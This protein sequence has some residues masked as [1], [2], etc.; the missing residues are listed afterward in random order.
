MS[1]DEQTVQNVREKLAPIQSLIEKEL[2]LEESLLNEEM[3]NI[4]DEKGEHEDPN[5]EDILLNEKN[6]SPLELVDSD[7]QDD[8]LKL[9][10]DDDLEEEAALL[11]DPVKTSELECPKTDSKFQEVI[12]TIEVEEKLLETLE[13][14]E[15]KTNQTSVTDSPFGPK[16]A[17]GLNKPDMMLEIP[18]QEFIE[19]SD[20]EGD[21]INNLEMSPDEELE[22]ENSMKDIDE[23]ILL[24]SDEEKSNEFLLLKD[25]AA[26]NNE[27]LNESSP[28]TDILPLEPKMDTEPDAETEVRLAADI[29]T[30]ELNTMGGENMTDQQENMLLQDD[31]D[32]TNELI[33]TL[34]PDN[35]IL[36]SEDISIVEKELH[37]N[38]KSGT[39][40]D[41]ILHS[42]PNESDQSTAGKTELTSVVEEIT[43]E[44][45]TE[46]DMLT[47]NIENEPKSIIKEGKIGTKDTNVNIHEE[48]VLKNSDIYENQDQDTLNEK[49]LK[50]NQKT[51]SKTG[52]ESLNVLEIDQQPSTSYALDTKIGKTSDTKLK[53]SHLEK[54]ASELPKV[55]NVDS[56]NSM[57]E[58]DVNEMSDS[59]GLLAETS[60][61]REED[62]EPEDDEDGDGDEDDD[63]DNYEDG[64]SY[65]W[66]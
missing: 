56:E 5:V 53:M 44:V 21:L 39:H 49:D 36:K 16:P 51:E 30:K 4:T 45:D 7:N 35:Q 40:F 28:N 37:L 47:K 11:E 34:E 25:K 15:S 9:T 17:H 54:K 55:F 62:E 42:V 22:N 33:E 19:F 3:S 2:D 57:F 64:M 58:S 1:S 27:D 23:E 60:R 8:D 46:S 20:E 48:E 61:L 18:M 50:P 32:D 52:K 26:K 65:F 59:L 24:G 31:P 12:K 13:V 63:F 41:S 38:S 66:C 10:W 14:E 6:D 43:M 29:L